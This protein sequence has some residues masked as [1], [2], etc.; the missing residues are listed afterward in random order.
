MAFDGITTKNILIEL[1]A[2]LLNARVEKVYVPTRND[3]FF[4][5]HTQTRENLKLLISIDANNARI[6]FSKQVKENPSKAPQICMILRKHL[7]GAKL[8][9]ISQHGLDRI[10][11][12]KF[13]NINELGDLVQKTL[14]VELMGKYSNVILVDENKKIIDSMRHVDITMSS[15]REVLPNKDYILPTT[16]G[17]IN[18]ETVTLEEF[19]NILN[20]ADI[21]D[22]PTIISNK[23]IGFSK[24]FV[25]SLVTSL[26]LTSTQISSN[27][28]KLIYDKLVEIFK[29]MQNNSFNF[30]MC[31]N[32]K[33]Y[34]LDIFSIC[35]SNLSLSLFLDNYYTQKENQSLIKNAKMNIIHDI[36]AHISKLNKK[37]NN[38]N[39]I[40]K[41]GENLEKYKQFGEL[42]NCNMHNLKIGMEKIEV[43]N[44]YDDNNLIT[45]PLQKNLTPSRNAQNYFKK[46]NKLKN[47]I[48]H[49]TAYKKEF[50]NDI[51][52]LNSVICELDIAESLNDV[53][54]IRAELISSG[55][56]KKVYKSNKKRDDIALEPLKYEYNGFTILVGRNNI[57]N[58]KLTFKIAKKTD[59]WL[60]TKKI[61]GSH[62]II[63]GE[64]IPDD[65]LLY[66]AKLAVLHSAGKKSSKV[67]VDYTLVKFV[68]KEIG[69]KPGMVVYTDY[70]SVIV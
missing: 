38:V 31:E 59:T 65:V 11:I 37:L 5:F 66:A 17:K 19:C 24:S 52:Y 53:D 55:Y 54:E 30:K 16:L 26:N 18:F 50:E 27:S 45:I 51:Y 25:N 7:Q 46:Y 64:N 29:V 20:S 21:S 15:V 23:F 67:E 47:S 10:I 13:E 22:L 42:L 9:S 35:E 58:D 44:F 6:H 3:I 28:L 69:A 62:V 34:F 4:N 12:F 49:A 48:T 14:I 8:L 32:N 56:I 39:E 60:H 1:N 40:L 63:K 57:Q 33:D 2:N 43:I 41:D 61:H 36:N 70:H 68:H